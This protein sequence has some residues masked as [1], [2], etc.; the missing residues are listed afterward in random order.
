MDTRDALA[1]TRG[2]RSNGSFVIT[3]VGVNMDSASKIVDDSF[4]IRFVHGPKF[5]QDKTA[6]NLRLAIECGWG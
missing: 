5:G 6:S 3:R 4:M 1:W 2:M